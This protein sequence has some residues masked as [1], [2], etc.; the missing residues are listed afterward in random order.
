MEDFTPQERSDR[1]AWLLDEAR[2]QGY[3]TLGAILEVFPETEDDL[4]RLDD[5]IALLYD[6][7][8]EVRDPQE[9]SK[10]FSDQV[11]GDAVEEAAHVDAPDLSRIPAD[12]TVSLYF[13]E[14]SHVPLLTVE[15]EVSLTRRIERG[16]EARRE[17]ARNGHNAQERS[18]LQRLIEQGEEARAH[19]I[20]ANTRLVVSV[21]KRYRG[22]GLPFLDLIQAGNVGLIKAADK[23][24]YRL[25]N[26]FCTYATWWIRQAITRSLSQQGRTIRIPVHMNA[27]IRRVYGIAQRLEQ[28]L[29]RRPT[30]EEIA[31]E[32]G[33]AL[34]TV[35]WL[36]RISWRPLSLERPVGEEGDSELGNFIEDERAPS[37]VET[38]ER[39]G[40][41]EQV[42]KLLATL[43]PRE[44][45]V[46]RLRFGMQGGR[47]HTLEEV[48]HKLG[49][50]RERA[51][52]IACKALR[53][54]RHPRRSRALR[55]F[56]R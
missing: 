43:P 37:P 36:L 5:L 20:K 1:I 39:S 12:D 6:Q 38:A 2:E 8:V 41:C 30:P 10:E 9:D 26:K 51:R 27:R 24:D 31:E 11:E 44:A 21:A 48:G 17:L 32:M 46:L 28:D 29:G 40:L 4:D 23:F 16:R 50:T 13:R 19:L 54:L 22:H 47:A 18:R 52:Q 49:V 55:T 7:G 53:K 34:A 56:L 42:E 25:G 15:E 45:R 33:M 14:M 35:R 3:L